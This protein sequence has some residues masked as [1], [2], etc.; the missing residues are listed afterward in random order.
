MQDP[1]KL[2]LLVRAF[3]AIQSRQEILHSVTI[4]RYVIVIL[5]FGRLGDPMAAIRFG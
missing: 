5:R 4:I 1:R 3:K 2:L